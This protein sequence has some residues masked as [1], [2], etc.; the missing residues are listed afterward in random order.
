VKYLYTLIYWLVFLTTCPLEFLV[1]LVVFGATAPFDPDRRFFHAFICRW[2]F[3]YL[4]LFPTWDV[5]VIGRELLPPGPAV[6]V[7]NHQSM[8]DVVAMMGLYHPFKFVSKASLFN[9]PLVGWAMRMARYVSLE[10]GR[11]RS[12]QD[13]METSRQWLRRGMALVLFPEG[14][15]STGGKMLPFKRGAF[16]L[17][18]EEKVPLVPVV[19]RG[20]TE[21]I[22]GDGP[23]ISPKAK[24]RVVVTPPIPPE[25]LGE[26]AGELAQRTQ[27]RIAEVLAA[28]G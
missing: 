10:R 12:T 16:V 23:W 15:Y 5:K 11:R 19:I 28:Q 17:A 1:G 14:T 18:I 24:V 3:Q 20:T 8:A 22:E 27:A 2:T 13:M 4:R 9:L 21:L 26:D 6:L 25:E 7:A